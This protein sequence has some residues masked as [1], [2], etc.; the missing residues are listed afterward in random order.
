ML[1]N[2][3]NKLA[4]EQLVIS[5]SKNFNA[6]KYRMYYFYYSIILLVIIVLLINCT[7]QSTYRAVDPLE[8]K[9]E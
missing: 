8:R 4:L 7:L 9:K 5:E 2:K 6:I 3:V 1:T